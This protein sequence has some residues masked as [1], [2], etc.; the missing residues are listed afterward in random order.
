MSSIPSI[1][2]SPSAIAPAPAGVQWI[3][4]KTAA[5]RA[6]MSVGHLQRQ[7]ARV[8]LA[9]E[10]ARQ[11]SGQG[12]RP[13]WEIREDADPKFSRVKSIDV[14]NQQFGLNH[15]SE[16]QRSAVLFR[17]AA[18]K[19]WQAMKGLTDRGS[20][21]EQTAMLVAELARENPAQSISARSLYRWECAY[22][23]HGRAGL[24]DQ[25]WSTPTALTGEVRGGNQ[26]EFAAFWK[27]L[28]S[29]WLDQNEPTMTT[30]YKLA[31]RVASREGWLIP[32][33]KS[34]QRYLQKLSRAKVVRGR[35]G[36]DAFANQC[37][38][39]ITR[40]Y[41]K[42]VI[43]GVEQPML[44]NDIWCGDHHICD[45][46]VMHE[47]KPIRPWLTAWMDLRSRVIVAFRF[48][49]GAPDSSSVLLALRD[50][51]L[52]QPSLAIPRYCYTDN[53]KDYACWMLNGSTKWDRRQ[54]KVEHDQEQFKG[55]YGHLQIGSM[56]AMPYNA[57]GKP[58]ERF[59]G[60]YE[61]QFGKLTHT[62]CGRDPQH[63]PPHLEDRLKRNQAPTFAEYA[64]DASAWIERCYHRDPHQGHGMDGQSPEQV[65]QSFLGEIRT[66][67]REALEICLMKTSRP[68][69]VG[70]NGVTWGKYCYGRGAAELRPWFGKDVQLRVDPADVTR[71]SVWTLDGRK[72]C[73]AQ[74]VEL[75]P[76][77]AMPDA[78]AKAIHSEVKRHNKSMA[79][80]ERYGMRRTISPIDVLL[81]EKLATPASKAST[82]PSAPGAAPTVKLIRTGFESP[83]MGDSDGGNSAEAAD[84]GESV[85]DRLMRITPE[86]VAQ[87][88]ELDP[89]DRATA[90]RE[91]QLREAAN[92]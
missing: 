23:T 5:A 64:A 37:G 10:Q 62:Y 39:Y 81:D 36:A 53:G 85:M 68:V 38:A 8:W 56:H 77:G 43:D 19:R 55:V 11:V 27:E 20:W 67:T 31:E 29:W 9:R 25:R 48:W 42:I 71:V 28:E 59:F 82:P 52:N 17:E 51:I 91:G 79:Q 61:Q 65:Y 50:G 75:A 63:K 14:L 74:E 60:T 26:E 22:T 89:W 6:G 13:Y 70:R 1:L 34:A 33:F 84:E 92:G 21:D 54:V 87:A 16:K 15:L 45:T 46:I 86:T 4:L 18:V 78:K 66:T 90:L 73:D 58:I 30:A 12:K 35:K 49:T 57:K 83:S 3:D 76:W 24:V 32:G 44:S 47:G 40:D 2:H 72:I 41:T 69:K 80:G 88:E 7:C